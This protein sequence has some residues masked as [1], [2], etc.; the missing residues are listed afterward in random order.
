MT[1]LKRNALAGLVDLTCA[2]QQI[3]SPTFCENKKASFVAEQF[4]VEGLEDIHIDQ[5][6]NVLARLP[7]GKQRP[8]IVSAHIDTVHPNSVPLTLQ[9]TPDQ[10]LGPSIGDNSLGMAGVIILARLIREENISL[11][12]DLWLV[13]NVCEEGLGDLRGM[14]ALVDNFGSDPLA[15]IIVEGLGLGQIYHR[16]LG[17][18]RYRVNMQTAGGHSWVDYG[19][20]SAINRLAAFITRLETLPV[21]R[22]P[23]TTLNV[24]MIQ[25]GTSINTIAAQASLELDLRSEDY[26]ALKSLSLQVKRLAGESIRPGVRVD[27]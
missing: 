4:G 11:P 5:A 12:G 24:G 8:V 6:G 27:V 10:L 17:V 15:Y 7:G 9:R 20:P 19:K 18:E 2:L 22:Q 21:P 23:R 14:R 3:P 16:G 13:G 25:G 26:N 1:R